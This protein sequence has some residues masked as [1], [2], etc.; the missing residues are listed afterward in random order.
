MTQ[1]WIYVSWQ[2]SMKYSLQYPSRGGVFYTALTAT[3]ANQLKGICALKF[4]QANSCQIQSN[5]EE[6]LFIQ[7]TR[8]LFYEGN[9]AQF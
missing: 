7:K 8:I 3:T 5:E 9:A 1:S 2:I 6:S 4:S